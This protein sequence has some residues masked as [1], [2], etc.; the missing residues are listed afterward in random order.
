MEFVDGIDLRAVYDTVERRHGSLPLEVSLHIGAEVCEA[1][2]HAHRA[3]NSDGQILRLVHRDVSP[4]NILLS[5][6]GEVKLTDFG[7]AKRMEE[8]TGHGGVRGKFAYISPEQAVNTHVDARSD[9]Y[10]CA[11]VLY[12]LVVGR[13]LFS[14]M[15]DFEALRA[16][17][18]GR[19]T[20]PRDVN[21]SVSPELEAMLMKA[22]A[23]NPADRYESAAQFGAELRAY[24]YTME[25]S[26]AD[27]A[28]EL[29]NLIERADREPLPP[30]Q[31]PRPS[32]VRISTAAGFSA[33]DFIAHDPK[34]VSRNVSPPRNVAPPTLP[35]NRQRAPLRLGG[36][37]AAAGSGRIPPPIPL[38]IEYADTAIAPFD[39][40]F[41]DAET[42]AISINPMPSRSIPSISDEDEET[43]LLQRPAD[44]DEFQPTLPSVAHSDD[45]ETLHAHHGGPIRAETP[46]VRELFQSQPPAPTAGPYRAPGQ[47][48]ADPDEEML[49]G[50][51]KRKAIL[52]LGIVAIVL[53][54]IAFVITGALLGSDSKTSATDPAP[55]AAVADAA[56]RPA[57]KPPDAGV[58]DAAPERKTRRKNRKKKRR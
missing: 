22:L 44:L 2:D 38:G 32:V 18:E 37:P 31:G 30:E 26:I 39:D 55:A 16:V 36:S 10:S 20:R 49:L 29:A 5:R 50:L 43:R 13:R 28:K 53:A 45:M 40:S 6:S 42:R 54:V 25:S 1:L 4:S 7:I 35:S 56:T 8:A 52:I 12:E 41:D 57:A 51:P 24:R 19:V 58:P 23:S 34:R 48:R 11:I 46:T 47:R 3:T 9:V 17:R 14:G 21:N 33:A 15:P 27:P